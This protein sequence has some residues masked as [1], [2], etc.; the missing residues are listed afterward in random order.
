VSKP[1]RSTAPNPEA[2]PAV[3]LGQYAPVESS[4][5]DQVRRDF[6]EHA[7]RA[8]LLLANYGKE[9]W[10]REPERVHRAILE[11]SW[12]DIGLLRHHVDA[13]ERDHRDVLP[14]AEYPPDARDAKTYGDLRRRLDLPGNE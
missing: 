12:G 5:D 1:G 14:W 3:L 2:R 7:D 10:H 8:L 11:L 13:A 4:T 6:G 9:S